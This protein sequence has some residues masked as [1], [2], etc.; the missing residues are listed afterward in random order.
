M[1]LS[2]YDYMVEHRPGT[3]MRHEDALSKKVN[4]IGKDL[5]LSRETIRNEQEKDGLCEKYKQYE[6]FWTDKDGVLYRQGSNE[7]LRVVIPATLVPTVLIC[8][9]D[10]PFP[11][12]QG[13][14]RTVEFISKTY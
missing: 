14:N 4:R 11:A 6:Y 13:V 12:H 1:K 2:V 7:Q 5:V 3:K 10:L 9:H 8:Y